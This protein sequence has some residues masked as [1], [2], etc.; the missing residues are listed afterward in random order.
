MAMTELSDGRVTMLTFTGLGKGTARFSRVALVGAWTGCVV[1]DFSRTSG[2]TYFQLI[3]MTLMPYSLSWP[4]PHYSFRSFCRP[5]Q[6]S[7]LVSNRRSSLL[8]SPHLQFYF[9]F[10][11]THSILTW[12]LLCLQSS[13]E[14]SLCNSLNPTPAIQY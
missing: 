14:R 1:L 8:E 10:S 12:R 11:R 7:K 5:R 9:T 2:P 6:L 3:Q 4:I 13:S